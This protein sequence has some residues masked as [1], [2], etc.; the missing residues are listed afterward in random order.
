MRKRKAFV[1][2]I[3]LIFLFILIGCQDTDNSYV[4][5]ISATQTKTAGLPI[6]TTSI[7]E[8][9][10]EVDLVQN[11]CNSG[12]IIA[13][14]KGSQYNLLSYQLENQ[15]DMKFKIN[16]NSRFIKWHPSG[17]VVSYQSVLPGEDKGL[18]VKFY[19]L[20]TQQITN[21]FY[22]GYN[23]TNPVWSPD[24]NSLA[25]SQWYGDG[26][27]ANVYVFNYS[28]G[29]SV[30]L[31]PENNDRQEI[32]L[33]WLNDHQL[34][35][36]S[37]QE[38]DKNYP[39]FSIDLTN[40]S[41]ELFYTSDQRIYQADITSDEKLLVF[42]RNYQSQIVLMDRETQQL[43][44]LEEIPIG[45]TSAVFSSD[46]NCISYINGG[47]IFFYNLHDQSISQLNVPNLEYIDFDWIP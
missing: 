47:Q 36:A 2:Y 46:D 34:L 14:F 29:T 6:T 25:F 21:P 37:N 33:V 42:L 40:Q 32:P 17:N 3:V 4:P 45:S 27:I 43:T 28:T 13:I 9:I 16:G 8:E 38:D 23:D 7:S 11:Q 35:I 30:N 18:N 39:L 5:T 15:I 12:R 24:G 1:L 20:N 10:N 22:I 31:S 19:Y 41:R 44:I 26:E